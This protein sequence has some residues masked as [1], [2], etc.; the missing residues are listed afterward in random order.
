ME[1]S[2][3]KPHSQALRL[4]QGLRAT[5]GLWSLI[6]EPLKAFLDLTSQVSALIDALTIFVK[7]SGAFPGVCCYCNFSTCNARPP[8]P[9]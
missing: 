6:C 5:L 8:P 1:D 3:S 9:E 7:R 4:W 2:K